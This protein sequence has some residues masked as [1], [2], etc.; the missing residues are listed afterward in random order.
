MQSLPPVSAVGRN[1]PFP[2]YR[3][4][5]FQCIILC[6]ERFSSRSRV[7]SSPLSS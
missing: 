5:R 3:S 1:Q 2:T 6:R 7:S 4:V